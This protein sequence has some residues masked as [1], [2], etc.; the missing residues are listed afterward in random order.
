MPYDRGNKKL[1]AV[2]LARLGLWID[3]LKKPE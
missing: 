1:D 3:N 2:E